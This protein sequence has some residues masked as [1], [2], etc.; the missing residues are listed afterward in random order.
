MEQWQIVV[1]TTGTSL[2]VTIAVTQFN[3]RTA[4]RS[5]VV[6]QNGEAVR[7]TAARLFDHQAKSAEAFLAAHSAAYAA[8]EL[9]QPERDR[10]TLALNVS[11]AQVGL[12]LTQELRDLARTV[13]KNLR[14]A[15]LTSDSTR[16]SELQNAA[17]DAANQLIG[18]INSVLST[19]PPVLN[20][21]KV[22]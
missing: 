20:P 6:Q 22:R 11:T 19:P 17:K 21:G 10:L 15:A 1:L 18:Q 9:Q 3:A 2:L 8:V 13:A 5:L 16:R 14:D 7:A 12:Y 4:M